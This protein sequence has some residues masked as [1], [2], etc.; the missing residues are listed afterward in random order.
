LGSP[1]LF[2]DSPLAPQGEIA[3]TPSA[4]SHAVRVLRLKESAELV[5]FNGDG[6]DYPARLVRIERRQAWARISERRQNPAEGPLRIHLGLG[7]SKSGRMDQ[8]IQKAVELGVTAITPL[9]CERSVVRLD[10]QAGQRKW[11]HWRGVV[12]SA[13]EQSGRALLPELERPRAVEAWLAPLPAESLKLLLAPDADSGLS[14]QP[15]NREIVLLIGP[16]GGI[17]QSEQSR[18]INHGFK[19]IRLGGR[20]LR[21]ETAPLAAIAAL[22]TLWGDFGDG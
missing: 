10:K 2:V 14:S 3:L 20:I 11:E 15:P 19:S 8:A 12:I 13:C 6:W 22:Q 4:F 9:L 5:L 7:I 17:S 18:A 21:T 16:E 1:R